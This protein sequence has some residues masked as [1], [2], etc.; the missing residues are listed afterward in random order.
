MQIYKYDKTAESIVSDSM[1][2]DRS[3]IFAQFKSSSEQI[4]FSKFSPNEVKTHTNMFF[5]QETVEAGKNIVAALVAVS[6]I[7][8]MLRMRNNLC[9]PLRCYS[10]AI[11]TNEQIQ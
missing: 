3:W 4:F 9:L 1:E 10:F 7:E 2:S 8:L 11:F 5:G 6:S